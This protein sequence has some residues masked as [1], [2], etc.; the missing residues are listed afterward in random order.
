MVVVL[1]LLAE[2]RSAGAAAKVEDAGEA[3]CGTA[4]S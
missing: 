3:S 4:V 2:S 1:L